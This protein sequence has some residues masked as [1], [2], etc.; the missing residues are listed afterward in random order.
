MGSNND[1]QI[2]LVIQTASGIS[3]RELV[4]SW[5]GF[6]GKIPLSRRLQMAC[7]RQVTR[8]EDTS[9]SLMGILGV[10]ISI[11]YGEGASRAFHRLIRELFNTKKNIMD[12]FNRTYID[13]EGLFPSSLKLYQHRQNVWDD[14][15]NES[16][17]LDQYPPL[18]PIIPTHLGI[19]TSLLLAPY[20]ITHNVGADGDYVAK[21]AL[22][23]KTPPWFS[24]SG[25]FKTNTNLKK[26]EF[27]ILLCHSKLYMG[28]LST[29]RSPVIPK[30]S[31]HIWMAG[32][33]NF[34]IDSSNHILL[35]EHAL[36]LQ[37]YWDGVD[38]GNFTPMG[39]LLYSVGFLSPSNLNPRQ[40]SKSQ[41]RNWK[42]M[43]CN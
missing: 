35:P 11:A 28:N 1:G 7:N 29:L 43:G 2:R 5:Q 26:S 10:D 17:H 9:Y 30:E 22:S 20:L 36:A 41:K 8:E 24:S 25:D 16:T 31:S 4:Q 6:I 13:R 32:I 34:G 42:N 23:A 21:G 27:H 40:G 12:L 39:M 14:F 3:I 37:L 15:S 19:H 18:D 38:K 33:V